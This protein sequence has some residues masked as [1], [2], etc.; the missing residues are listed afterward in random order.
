MTGKRLRLRERKEEREERE[1]KR[2]SKEGR[3]NR[4]IEGMVN[5][6]RSSGKS[7]CQRD[8]F[9]ATNV[10]SSVIS[11]KVLVRR[12]KRF[13]RVKRQKTFPFS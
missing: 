6:N 7:R 3:G 2:N 5:E 10:A 4:E 1:R 8:L 11:M 13:I 9:L 12:I